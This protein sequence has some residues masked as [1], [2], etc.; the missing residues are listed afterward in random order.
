L[1]PY[2]ID[3]GTK[4]FSEHPSHQI[5][6]FHSSSNGRNIENIDYMILS[7]ILP[8]HLV[9]R[10]LFLSVAVTGDKYC[11][12]GQ[13]YDINKNNWILRSYNGSSQSDFLTECHA[14]CTMYHTSVCYK[15][16]GECIKLYGFC[17]R[18]SLSA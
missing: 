8:V 16:D 1:Q 9:D 18:L 4:N 3:S 6:D 2:A 7:E 10:L 11:I 14:Y 12:F 15:V 5:H 13:A 17:C